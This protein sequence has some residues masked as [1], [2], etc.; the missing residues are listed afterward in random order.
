MT[1][2]LDQSGNAWHK[3]RTWLGPSLGWVDT[4]VKPSRRINIAGSYQV[5]PGDGVIFVNVPGSVTLSLPD[6]RLWV[7]EP[8]YQ[9]ATAFERVLVVKDLGGNAAANPIIVQPFA[10]QAIDQSGAP[11]QVN[12]NHGFMRLYPLVD[13]TGW[14]IG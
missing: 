13:L 4:Q 3:V 2:D 1:T 8:A 12:T 5:F 7:S 6:V 9:P 10:G 11:V 14:W